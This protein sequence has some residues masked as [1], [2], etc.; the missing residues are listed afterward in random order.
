MGGPQQKVAYRG[1]QSEAEI[2][3]KYSFKQGLHR[4]RK[5]KLWG[6]A[7]LAFTFAGGGFLT[8]ET[9]LLAA[10]GYSLSQLEG[11]VK[12][13]E[14]E[15]TQLRAEVAALKSP[16]RIAFLAREELGMTPPPPEAVAY[17]HGGAV[18]AQTKAETLAQVPKV[19]EEAA[20]S[21]FQALA[22][23]LRQTFFRES[24]AR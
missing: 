7:F 6:L 22:Q 2:L 3:K 12:A 1:S 9:S 10:K 24:W 17:F 11:Q 18:T 23:L 20:P 21:F 14:K 15:N 4:Y 13:L 8:W 16:S 19:S 5:I